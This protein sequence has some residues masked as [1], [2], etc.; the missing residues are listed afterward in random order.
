ML[1]FWLGTGQS[2]L[3]GRVHQSMSPQPTDYESASAG[4]TRQGSPETTWALDEC[5]PKEG[6][7]RRKTQLGEGKSSSCEAATGRIRPRPHELI[8]QDFRRLRRVLRVS[9]LQ[10]SRPAS[11]RGPA[12]SNPIR[13]MLGQ[14]RQLQLRVKT[15]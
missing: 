10:F 8:G 15:N 6:M 5:L 7:G 2:F 12:E 9:H 4:R 13:E 14:G 11:Q 3:E 1:V